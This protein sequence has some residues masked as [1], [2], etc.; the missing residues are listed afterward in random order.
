[1]LTDPSEIHIISKA[2]QKN[3]RDPN[4]SRV[5][6]D[7]IFADF[8]NDVIFKSSL[9]LDLGPG[10]YDFGVLARQKGAV[11]YGIDNDPSVIELGKYKGFPVR[12]GD[13]EDIKKEDF[14]TNFDGIFCKYSIDAFWFQDVQHLERHIK[15]I[16]KLIRPGGW[17]WIAP[18]NG[19]YEDEELSPADIR[20]ALSVQREVFKDLGFTAFE[21]TEDLS[22]YYGVHGKTANRALFTLNLKMSMKLRTCVRI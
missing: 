8:L 7:H 14:D 19:S 18:W 3:V 1:M 10:Q 13:I 22:K 21:L 4:R 17:A 9:L 16:G 20:R 5:H 6:F 11:T 12:Y 2:I 15:E